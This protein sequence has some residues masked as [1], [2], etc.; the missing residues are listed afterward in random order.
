MIAL[1]K[2]VIS[3]IDLTEYKNTSH[4]I[5]R[6]KTQQ[7]KKYQHNKQREPPPSAA[8]KSRKISAAVNLIFTTGL[9]QPSP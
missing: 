8:E 5:D 2:G 7:N 3:N 9:K 6:I 1:K 4:Y